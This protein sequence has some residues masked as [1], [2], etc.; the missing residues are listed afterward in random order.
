MALTLSQPR[1]PAP[2][3]PVLTAAS[4]VTP[5]VLA[6]PALTTDTDVEYLG[7]R[8]I[9]LDPAAKPIAHKVPANDEGGA[10]FLALAAAEKAFGM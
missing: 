4:P 7:T 5:P 10:L 3:T 8:T 1:T 6:M 9:L 2:D